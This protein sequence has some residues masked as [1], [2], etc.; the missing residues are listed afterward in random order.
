MPQP[1]T[2]FLCGDV[3]TGRGVDQILPCPSNP[4]LHEPYV[5]SAFEYVAMA[6]AANGHIPSHVS[7]S[8]IWGDALEELNRVSPAARIINLETSVTTS[9]DYEHK[10]INYRMHPANT[11]CLSAANIDCCVLAN[12]HVLDWGRAGLS[13]TICALRTAGIK[14]AGAGADLQNAWAP[15]AIDTGSNTRVLVLAV[16]TEDSGIEPHWAATEST[17]GVAFLPDLSDRTAADLAECVKRQK[18]PGD[19]AVLS[20][21]WGG[22]WGYEIPPSQ[23]KFARKLVDSAEIDVVHG[24]SSH[25][26]KGIEVYNGKPILYGCGDFLDDYEGI[27]GY[28]EFRTHLVL[29]YFITLDP[30]SGGLVKLEMAAFEIR[31]FQLRRASDN[32][33]AWLKDVMS[34]EGKRL[35]TTAHLRHRNRL[36][37]RWQAP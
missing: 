9:E 20:I 26:P 27:T 6:E 37:L 11:P 8:Y 12:N 32:D 30:G 15:A 28:E 25:H 31:R 14:T 23:R 18:R 35:G 24:H 19:I 1:L 13:Q 10:G 3:M 34:R 4:S 29:G 2:L 21:H 33:A 17:P 36:E 22:N 16:G 5:E 7:F